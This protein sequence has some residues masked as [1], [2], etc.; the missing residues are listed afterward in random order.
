M[1][2]DRAR[3]HETGDCADSRRLRGAAA[4]SLA[5][6][7]RLFEPDLLAVVESKR[8]DAAARFRIGI[9][10]RA[11]RDRNASEV[12]KR[13]VDIGLIGGGAPLHAAIDA[14]LADA[15]LPEHRA[16]PI[17]IDRV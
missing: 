1:S 17:R 12:G 11:V 13:D 3:E 6:R 14:A 2:V 7:W 15:P 5:A 16:L 10:H 9:G 4:R 8:E